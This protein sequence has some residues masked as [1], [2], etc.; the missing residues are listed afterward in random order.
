M[1][2]C[3]SAVEAAGLDPQVG[4][5]QVLRPGRAELAL[6]LIEAFR[7]IADRIALTPVNRSEIGRGDFA[8][9]EGGAVLLDGDMRSTL[10]K[11]VFAFIAFPIRVAAKYAS[12][13]TFAHA[14]SN[15]RWC[16]SIDP[17]MWSARQMHEE[18]ARLSTV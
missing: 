1:N 8:G 13:E 17:R 7:C 11:T 9:R 16:C 12:T 10:P 6:D 18:F 5:L 15:S 4:F 3:R 2:D 14:I